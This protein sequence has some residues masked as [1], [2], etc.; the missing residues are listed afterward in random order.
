M[1]Q[2]LVESQESPEQAVAQDELLQDK[3]ESFL[4]WTKFLKCD[5]TYLSP[6]YR[7]A[8]NFLHSPS[9]RKFMNWP[10][11]TYKSTHLCCFALKEIVKNP[12]IRILYGSETYGQAKEYV[13]WVR[14]QFEENE[15]L[16]ARY[17]NLVG[18]RDWRAEKFTVSTRT[19]LAKKESTMT[20]CGIDV[21]KTGG[22]YDLIIIDDPVSNTN[23]MTTAQMEK[24]LAWYKLLLSI[25]EPN[26]TLILCGT[27]YDE[28][29]LYGEILRINEKLQTLWDSLPEEERRPDLMPY[30]V[31]VE[32]ATDDGTVEG[33]ILYEH[34]D[35]AFL[36]QKLIEQ[37]PYI[38]SCQYMNSPVNHENAVFTREMFQLIRPEDIP[39]MTN[40]YMLTDT[41]VTTDGCESV[42]FMFS[43][44]S[45]DN[46]YV[47]DCTIGQ[48]KPDEY[49][50]Q[51]FSLY[52]KWNPR[53]CLLEKVPINHNYM[54]MLERESRERQSPIKLVWI[55]GRTREAKD[56]RILTMQGR[57]AARRIFFSSDINKE[58]IHQ[59]AGLCYG[60][61]VKQFINFRPKSGGKKDILDCLSDM[62]KRDR[63]SGAELCPYPRR[64][65]PE[66]I[67]TGTINGRYP[68]KTLLSKGNPGKDF[69]S[70]Q[71]RL[72]DRRNRNA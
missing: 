31:L 42:N 13:Q 16:R 23:T 30:D 51:F 1:V 26:G 41:A 56:D 62:D 14:S 63:R 47:L 33:K 28:D 36:R 11:G 22:H 55:N 72:S 50:R 52:E 15:E 3:P 12:N 44:D 54:T 4:K 66:K 70:T 18:K 60:K 49:V 21:T 6:R 5:R 19:D 64:R 39:K 17:G 45:I 9:R 38:F 10:R 65:R 37:G 67:N 24:T 43:K 20:A 68:S 25:L 48:W 8:Y 71:R 59:K 46:V 7:V 35:R 2:K 29:D 58:F 40:T 53:L 61:I 32:Q 57:F 69:W 34:L 27:R